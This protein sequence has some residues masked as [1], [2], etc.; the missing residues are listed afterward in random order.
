VQLTVKATGYEEM[1]RTDIAVRAGQELDLG[2][3]ALEPVPL[4]RVTVTDKKSKKPIEG[5]VVRLAKQVADTHQFRR[6][7]SI[8]NDEGAES[9]DFG[10]SRSATTDSNGVAELSSY[11]GETVDVSVRAKGYA[12][13]KHEGLALPRGE[14]IEDALTLSLGGEVNVQVLDAQG[15]AFPGVPVEHRA[16]GAGPE[17]GVFMIGG[18]RSGPVTDAQGLALFE[19]LAPGLHSFRLGEKGGG[20]PVFATADELVIAG[21]GGGGDDESWTQ[22]TVVEGE[23][24][25]LTLRAAPRS[26]LAGRVREAGKVLAGATLS[27]ATDSDNGPG[28]HLPGMDSGGP[29]GK[30]DGEGHYQVEDVKAGHYTLTVAHPTRRMPAEFEI[31]LREGE[32]TFDVELPLSIVSGRVLDSEGK[33]L[34]GVRV[35]PERQQPEGG[36][37]VRMRMIMVDGDGGGGMVDSGQFGERAVSDAEGRY[38]LRGVTSDVDLVIKAEGDAVQPAHSAVVRLGPNE[39]K[40]GID[41]VLEVAGSIRVEA[42]LADGSPARFQLVQAEYL[43]ES[44]TPLEPK[45]GFLQQGSTELTGL[46]PGR[47]KVN[48]R[49]AQGGPGQGN[50]GQDK[51]IEVKPQEKATATF[52]VE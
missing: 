51:E 37:Q 44:P 13:A 11:E 16:A 29:E 52:E 21:G 10:E 3:I 17:G 42:K 8:S 38:T 25:E 40:E 35:W 33:G 1:H 32:N 39:V 48:V 34:A 5:A 24:A 49:S 14:T 4:L 36:R 43:D 2:V 19:N 23:R 6:S 22:V 28:F 18:P 47:W 27:L 50:P 12:P 26:T 31:D 15:V 41:L 46:K 45:F 20:G 7:I 9:V 30:S